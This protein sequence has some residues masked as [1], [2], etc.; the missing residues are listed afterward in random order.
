MALKA[1]RSLAR[2]TGK[3]VDRLF[4]WL[5]LGSASALLALMAIFFLDL[6][7]GSS[8]TLRRLGI[9]FLYGS[10]WNPVKDIFG[11]LPLIYGS[12]ATSVI[13]LILGVP[14]SLGIAVFLSEFSPSSWSRPVSFLVE[15]LAAVPSVVYG[16][17]GIFVLTPFL[18]VNVYPVLQAYL[19]FLPIFQGKIY[20]VSVLTAGIIL[21][22]MIIPIVA[23]IS[24]D[25][26]RAVPNS[27]REAAYA[28]GATKGEMVSTA[29]LGNARSGVIASIF[30][31]FGRAF[32]ETMA[33][34]MV[35]GNTPLISS[36]LFS[37]GYTMASLIANE[38]REAT[39]TTYISAIVEVGLI[40][41]LVSVVVNVV[42]RLLVQRFL[43]SVEG[44]A[45]T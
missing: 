38:F 18:R 8:I 29:V 1:E 36:S 45:R 27:Q 11:A 41:L 12:I 32:G 5:F 44:S 30:L 22:V 35:I 15:M 17:W 40:L 21:A 37:P 23:A 25:A 2:S 20:G 9:E 10:T 33:V 34:T 4:R 26:L 3:G 39:T 19:G 14:V 16:L 28:L 43:R 42:G 13:A 7:N 31:G 24:R 6:V